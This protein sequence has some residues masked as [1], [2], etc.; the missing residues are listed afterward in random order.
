MQPST[1]KPTTFTPTRPFRPAFWCANP[2]LQTIAG[3]LLRNSPTLPVERQRWETPDGDFLDL[4]R[5]P[6]PQSQSP[7]LLLIHG[8]ESS[9][10]SGDIRNLMAL[11]QQGGFEAI[12]LNFR[13][14]SGVPNRL[15]R[16]YHSGE[17]GDLGWV[18]EQL[19]LEDASC[20]IACVGISLGG[21]VLL[22]YLGEQSDRAPIQGAVAISTPFDLAKSVAYTETGFSR[23]YIDR[24]VKSLKH[25][26]SQ[27][28]AI[29]PDLIDPQALEA[30]Q[31]LSDFDE[32]F[33]A[34]IHGFPDAMTYWNTCSSIRFLSTIARPTL[35]ISAQDDPFF[36]GAWLPEAEVAANEHLC[37]LFPE[38]GGH[39]AFVESRW[40]W[41]VDSWAHEQAIAFLQQELTSHG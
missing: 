2:H 1:V 23:L 7:R 35:L 11:G 8:L 13:S 3:A 19:R 12:A 33:T 28:R 31:T 6:A 29:H 10:E 24:F 26:V 17:T 41:R 36:P 4:D 5:L 21:N 30:V 15:K 20:A 9:S 38:Q 32:L 22:K 34:P 39:A 40:P 18:I 16:A 37:A 14:C 25:K 27:K